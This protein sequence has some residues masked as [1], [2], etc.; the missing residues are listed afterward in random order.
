MPLLSRNIGID[1][2]T[3]NT[4]IYIEDQGIVLDEASAV[5]YDTKHKK[6][7]G[8]G[9]EAKSMLGRTPS[10]I[11]VIYP[12]RDGV[13]ADYKMPR[14]CFALFWKKQCINMRFSALKSLSAFHPK[15]RRLKKERLRML[16]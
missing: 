10:A 5:A 1:L 6:I 8:I 14:S 13:I 9:D 11:E 16:S 15:R 3:A 2:G 12:L 4:R 7:V